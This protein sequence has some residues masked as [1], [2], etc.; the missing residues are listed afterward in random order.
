[1][2]PT[3]RLSAKC[4]SIP[5]RRCGMR[6]HGMNRN[7]RRNRRNLLHRPG[8]IIREIRLVEHNDRSGAAVGHERQQTFDARQVEIPVRRRD[9]EH[10]VDIRRQ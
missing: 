7:A 10:Y 3:V 8:D 9:D 6:A 5:E 2:S 4:R 1:M